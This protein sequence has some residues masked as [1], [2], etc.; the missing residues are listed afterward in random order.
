MSFIYSP[1]E[2]SYLLEKVILENLPD[3]VKQNSK[4]KF[5][6]VGVGSG[7]QLKAA[8]K[9]GVKKENIFGVDVNI[10]A[11]KH[12]Q[13]E[14]FHCM[15]SNLFENVKEK[16]DVIVFNPPYL[17][18]D[19]NPEDEESKLITTGGKMGSEIPNE[20]L[21]QAKEHLKE[22]G[23]IFLLISSLTKGIDWQD[24]KKELMAEKKLFFEKLEV[25]K[26]F[27]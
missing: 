13:N 9:A 17:P 26:L 7:I 19:E 11:V 27:L 12:C 18:E 5:L 8:E 23:I 10:D 2:D 16:F 4:L 20:F 24:Y 3:L 25:Y 1:E 15:K 6:E 14:G 22:N 21:K